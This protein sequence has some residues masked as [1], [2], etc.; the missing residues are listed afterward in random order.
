MNIA[1]NTTVSKLFVAF[2]AVAMLFTVAAPAKAATVEEL[3][4][5]IAALMAQISSLSG[6]S[7]APAAGCTFT[8]ALTTGS[9]GA[10]VTCLQ[11][12]LIGAGHAISAGATGYFGSQTAAAVASWQAANGVTPAAGYF[13]PVS[14][15]KYNALMAMNGGSTPGGDDSDDDSSTGG[16]SGEA[17]LD[18]AELDGEEST[19]EEGESD[20]VVGT[21]TVEF[22]DGDA[23]ISRLDVQLTD[24]NGDAEPWEA[25]ETVTLWVDGDEVASMDAS[26]EDEYL[27]EDT[28]ELRF[29]GLDIVASEDEELEIEIAV[30]TQSNLDQTELDAEWE[31]EVTSIRY[32]DADDVASTEND[33]ANGDTAEFDMDVEGADEELSLSLSSSNPDSTD[34]IVDT[35]SDTTDVTIMVADLEAEDNDIE[36]N[37]VVVLVT[38][39]GTTTDVVDDIRVVIDGQEFDAEAVGT[40]NDYSASAD[41]NTPSGATGISEGYSELASATTSIWY[42]F[43]IDGDVVI[44]ADT[45]VEMEVVVDLNDTDDGARYANG[46]TISAEVTSTER[47]EWQAEGA[48]DL[49]PSTQFSGTAV[50]D[51]HTLVAE[52]ILVPVDGFTS[53]VDTLGQNDTIGEFTLEFE[54]E[55]VEGDFYIT[56]GTSSTTPS[57]GVRYSVDGGA[58]IIS[59]SLTSTADEDTAGVFTVREGET[60]TF[61]LVVTVDPT[62]TGTFRVSLDQVWYSE[63]TNGLGGEAYLPTPVSDFRTASQAIQG[64]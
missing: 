5:Q 41:D 62:A 31:L 44:D 30:S 25:F 4:A 16:L 64:S 45:E 23:E 43:D 12:Y 17:S 7:S 21:F 50:G 34:I 53:E 54:V 49:D 26:D 29:S 47:A 55:A 13:G 11:N 59:A 52:G 37:R 32:F 40:E 46:V 2:V 51:D 6:G 3:Q 20:V 19:V 48:D 24:T 61:T 1:V 33:P 60:E 63:N 42:L 9:T 8:R 56:E 57:A 39:T 10:D 15:A 38:T 58:A 36:L 27:D 28:G 35:D 18:T 22:Q 14:Q